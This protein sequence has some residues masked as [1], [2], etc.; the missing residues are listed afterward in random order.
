MLVPTA[1][2]TASNACMY[3][4]QGQAKQAILQH[5]KSIIDDY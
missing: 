4:G 3:I 1:L 2:E 5:V